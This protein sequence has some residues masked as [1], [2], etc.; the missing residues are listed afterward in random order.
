MSFPHSSS[1]LFHST[2][3]ATKNIHNFGC[4][5]P[6]SSAVC[7]TNKICWDECCCHTGSCEEKQ[8]LRYAD[9][10]ARNR[11]YIN[12]TCSGTGISPCSIITAIFINQWVHSPGFNQHLLSQSSLRRYK[13]DPVFSATHNQQALHT[14]IMDARFYP[15]FRKWMDGILVNNSSL[16]LAKTVRKQKQYKRIVKL[17]PPPHSTNSAT[18]PHSLLRFSSPLEIQQRLLEQCVYNKVTDTVLVLHKH[19]T[20]F[21]CLTTRRAFIHWHRKRIAYQPAGTRAALTFLLLGLDETSYRSR[22]QLYSLSWPSSLF[23]HL[24]TQKAFCLVLLYS[25]HLQ[26]IHTFPEIFTRS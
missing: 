25:S 18:G 7:P 19:S 3:T 4:D 16:E 1:K 8:S 2:N 13:R 24:H 11:I 21:I 23:Y 20:N 12:L 26:F 15:D 9:P 17:P 14:L 5:R 6:Q 22:L 10:Q